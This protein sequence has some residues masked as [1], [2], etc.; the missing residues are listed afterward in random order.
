[1]E[2]IRFI[3][4]IVVLNLI[5][6]PLFVSLYLKKKGFINSLE[7]KTTKERSIPYLVSSLFYIFTYF[8][9]QQINFPPFYLAIFRAAIF[10]IIAL[11]IFSLMGIKASAH[12][13]GMGGLCGMI[14]MIAILLK[15]EISVLFIIF[16]L[17]S[18]ITASARYA[19]K[20]HS[21]GE[22]SLGFLLGF[23]MQ[24]SILY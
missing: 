16:I 21:L 20:A 1:M 19:L 10:V 23:G 22:L 9:F 6:S 15:V 12:L 5:V 13:A 4:G 11:M 8:L 24:L 7:M 17:L 18:G 2:M 14:F 3:Y